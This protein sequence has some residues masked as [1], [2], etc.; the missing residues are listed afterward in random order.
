MLELSFS[1]TCAAWRIWTFNW[2][3]QWQK[4]CFSL[5]FIGFFHVHLRVILMS[6]SWRVKFSVCSLLLY[7][8][9]I[10][11]SSYSVEFVFVPLWDLLP[12]LSGLVVNFLCQFTHVI[13]LYGICIC[14]WELQWLGPR[15]SSEFNSLT[16]IICLKMLCLLLCALYTWPLDLNQEW[17][18]CIICLQNCCTEWCSCIWSIPNKNFV[19]QGFC[20][21]A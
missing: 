21:S 14:C 1:I 7:S 8:S 18:S 16:Q 3:V 5:S 4:L 20:A 6:H 9:L 17:P 2:L 19:Y 12:F 15:A 10:V 11:K 13:I